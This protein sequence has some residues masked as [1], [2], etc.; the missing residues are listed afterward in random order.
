MWSGEAGSSG[1]PGEGRS[2]MVSASVTPARVAWLPIQELALDLQ[3]H[4]Q[5]EQGHERVIDPMQEAE[6]PGLGVEHA[7]VG[8][9]ER[10]RV[11]QIPEQ[12][13]RLPASVTARAAGAEVRSWRVWRRGNG[14]DW[15][16]QPKS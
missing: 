14:A 8:R 1:R 9:G 16:Q 10:R 4:E 3:A 15:L 6:A 2:G 11:L 7:E 13:H 12:C 5:K